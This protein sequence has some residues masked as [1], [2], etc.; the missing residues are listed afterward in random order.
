[1]PKEKRTRPIAPP[2]RKA[3][4][5]CA[6][7]K[8][9]CDHKTPSCSRCTVRGLKCLY[10]NAI[11]PTATND[12]L[13]N[14]D[15]SPAAIT[16]PSPIGVNSLSPI[17][18]H[19]MRGSSQ[20][21]SHETNLN[22]G[23]AIYTTPAA[24]TS[25]SPSARYEVQSVQYDE[26]NRRDS[27]HVFEHSLADLVCNIDATAIRNRWLKA[28]IPDPDHYQKFISPGIEAYI[29]RMLK[30]YTS[31][32]IH[33]SSIPP[34]I[35]EQQLISNS[36][37]TPLSNCLGLM[38]L[39]DSRVCGNGSLVL[40]LLE[41]EM[42]KMHEQSQNYDH[43]TLL[44]AF[45]AYLI[46]VMVMFF[47]LG[48]E[49]TALRE[50]MVNL[51]HLACETSTHGLLTSA[52]LDHSRPRWGSWIAAEAKR[53]TLYIMYLF[54]NLLCIKDGLPIFVSPELTGLPAPAGKQLWLAA[55]ENVWKVAYNT[56]LSQWKQS[57]LLLDELW[58]IPTTLSQNGII[59]RR[60]RVDQWLESVDEYGAM[61]YAVTICTH[62]G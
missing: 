46:Y 39:C 4:D 31:C 5:P 34:F 13:S 14:L 42:T 12:E 35:H 37:S 11:N 2:R 49:S 53:R 18:G 44:G 28:F 41:R 1:M 22:F 52:E 6:S 16:E 55:T 54:D 10:P 23:N 15:T 27:T 58:P 32:I 40:E 21:Y 48:K 9:R 45:Q 47:N 7:V 51:Q 8:V 59:E 33:G 50:H 61:L 24:S 57:G 25:N 20:S 19:G 26:S 56:H 3:C 60:G 62:G 17:S 29:S 43:L 30:A 36:P 38:K